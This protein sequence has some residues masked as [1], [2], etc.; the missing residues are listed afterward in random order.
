MGVPTSFKKYFWE[1]ETEKLDLKKDAEYIIGRVL[2]YGN[3]AAVQWMLRTFDKE[4]IKKVL[5]R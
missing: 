2:E 1:A 4:P 5:S 3:I